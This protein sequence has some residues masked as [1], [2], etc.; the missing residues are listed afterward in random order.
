MILYLRFPSISSFLA[1]KVVL[2][3]AF[4]LCFFFVVLAQEYKKKMNFTWMQNGLFHLFEYIYTVFVRAYFFLLNYF[5][6]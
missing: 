4:D 3:K 5:F 1:E 2:P 6:Y